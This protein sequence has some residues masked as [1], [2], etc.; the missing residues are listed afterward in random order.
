MYSEKRKISTT[1]NGKPHELGFENSAAPSPI[2][3]TTGQHKAYWILPAEERIKGFVRPVRDRYVHLLCGGITL[4][5]GKDIAETYARDPKYYGS[6]M[7]VH[8]RKHYP[9]RDGNGIP[10][11]LWEPDGEPVG[12]TEEEAKQYLMEQVAREAKK[13]LGDGI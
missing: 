6:T 8:C 10:M 4:I 2:D 12:S 9:L 1:T 11:F 3:P 5:M 13:H 7:C